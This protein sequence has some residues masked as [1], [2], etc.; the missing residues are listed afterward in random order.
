MLRFVFDFLVVWSASRV[1]IGSLFLVWLLNSESPTYSF[2]K[3]LKEKTKILCFLKVLEAEYKPIFDSI[4]EERRERD[5]GR[6]NQRKNST[7]AAVDE[8]PTTLQDKAKKLLQA[9]PVCVNTRVL[10]FMSL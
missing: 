1:E 5:D 4:E 2:C 9:K 7:T 8:P 3:N 6:K 10:K